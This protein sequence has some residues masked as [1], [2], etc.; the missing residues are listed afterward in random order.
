[1]LVPLVKFNDNQA[2]LLVTDRPDS[3]ALPAIVPPIGRDV[4]APLTTQASLDVVVRWR[5]TRI[6]NAVTSPV[7]SRGRTRSRSWRW[8]EC[9]VRPGTAGRRC[10]PACRRA[11]AR[12]GGDARWRPAGRQARRSARSRA[13]RDGRRRT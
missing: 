9:W 6:G 10:A 7:P 3:V 5:G 1:E 12:P 4:A 13:C 11:P 8:R 2:T